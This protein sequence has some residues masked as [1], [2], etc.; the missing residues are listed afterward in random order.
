MIMRRTTR[1]RAGGVAALASLA[2]VVAACG[3]SSGTPAKTS[4]PSSSAANTSMPPSSSASSSRSGASAG[5][6]QVRTA[7]GTNGTF[8]TDSAGR[9]LYLWVADSNGMSSCSGSCARAWPPLTT[10]GMPTASGGATSSDLGTITRSDGGKQVTYKGHPLYYFAGDS[11]PG[12]TTGQGSDAFGAKW[13][14]VAPSGTAITSSGS[15]ASSGTTTQRSSG[16][17][18]Q[19]SSS[20]SGGSTQSSGGGAA[21]GGWG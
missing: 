5:G 8:L 12:K 1:I 16:G 6:V 18:G 21:G 11:G 15:P 17:G 9:S 2:L 7:R 19:S 10:K 3:S 4:A 14:L 13:W 20:S